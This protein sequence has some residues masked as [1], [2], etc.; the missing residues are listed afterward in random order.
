[1]KIDNNP[2]TEGFVDALGAKGNFFRVAN[3]FEWRRE[4]ISFSLFAN[5]TMNYIPTFV[6]ASVM[7]VPSCLHGAA[8]CAKG[9]FALWAGSLEG[10]WMIVNLSTLFLIPIIGTVICATGCAIG[11]GAGCATGAG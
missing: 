1:M 11:A 5:L 4:K 3:I 10:A 7:W 8:A 9:I 6:K 2:F